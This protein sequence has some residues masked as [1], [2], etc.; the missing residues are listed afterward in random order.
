MFVDGEPAQSTRP[1]A[2]DELKHLA[3]VRVAGSNPVFRS[4]V[5]VQAQFSTL[6]DSLRR[7]LRSPLQ[8]FT[9]NGRSRPGLPRARRQRL[10]L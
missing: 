9:V 6:F 10:R 8:I 4:I 2:V 5:G 7:R 3:K 1:D